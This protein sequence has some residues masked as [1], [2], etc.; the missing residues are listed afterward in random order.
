MSDDS[1]QKRPSPDALLEQAKKEGC[2][3]LKIFL[4]A[5]PGVGKTYEM[6]VQARQRK[7]EGVDIVI[8]VAETHGRVETE[9]LTK[10]FET[11]PKKRVLY[12]GLVLAEMDIDAILQRRPTLVLVDEL[13]H[14]N[15]EGSRHPKRYMDVEELLDAGIDVYTTLNIQ[16]V[17][18][19]NDI[20]A[21]ITRIQVRETVPDSIIDR[22]DDIEVVDLTPDDLIRR[23]KDGKVYLPETAERAIRNYFT[24]GNLTALREL[25]LRLTAQRVDAQMRN[26]M[27]THAIEGPWEAG[28]RVLVCINAD[29]GCFGLVRYGRR[30][31]DRLKAPW[32][33]IHVET[34]REQLTESERDR[35]ADCLRLAQRL[36][37]E[38]V[39]IPAGDIAEGIVGY[40]QANNFTHL[41]LARTRRTRLSEII[42]GSTAQ[43]IMR[44]SGDINVHVISD[45]ESEDPKS[46]RVEKIQ[47][48][49]TGPS[50]LDPRSYAGSFVISLGAL[51]VSLVLRHFG[52]TNVALVFLA[53]VLACAVTY[54]LWP[55]LF[56]CLLSV[57][58]YNFFFLPPLYTFTIADPENVVALF[59]FLVVALIGSNLAARLRAQVVAARE[60]AKTTEDLYLFSRKLG[61]IV[62]L[63]DLLWA[64][65]YQIA[66]MLKLR[67]VVLLPE[68]GRLTVRTGYPP[69]DVLS[70]ADLAAAK[71][72][73]ENNA[74]T[75]RGADTLPGAR[76]LFLPMRTGRGV[77]GV[78]GLDRDRPG[79]MLSPDQRRLLDAL[80]DQAALAIERIKLAEDV[81]RAKIAAESERLRNA[82]L[83]SISHDLRTPLA[84]IIGAATGLKTYRE[85]LDEESQRELIRTIQEEADRLNHF[86]GNLLD[87]TRLESG[88]IEPHLD[89]VDLSD[90]VG[91]ALRR[92]AKILADHKTKLAL[93]PDLPML[94]LDP[95]L[96][97]QV[98]FNLL[99]NAAKY[100]PPQ[101]TIEI[102]AR[103]DGDVV[104]LEILDEGDGIP[105]ADLERIFDKFYRVHVGDRRRVG[106]GLGLAICRGFVEAMGGTI[107]AG[108]R[109][110]RKG[111]MFTI[112][113]PVPAEQ[114]SLEEKAA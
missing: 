41:V 27:Q 24:H 83:T 86:I 68:N 66:S 97:E 67:V 105:Q 109:P 63:D 88:A 46:R 26:Y 104:R 37:G 17:E 4:G 94:K 92:T 22:A 96:F 33:V 8:G 103:R 110:D 65:A 39:T 111:A 18:S 81:D 62:L 107:R 42:R 79:P 106:T 114:K 5:A 60:R 50:W 82:L 87:M 77:I 36:G 12:K 19:L 78:V 56:A 112:T 93:A 2:G 59:F 20:V 101:T 69:E 64:T 40:A 48:I 15:V 89:P 71:W 10:G 73:F 74:P 54:G 98:L 99:D 61:G 38:A 14:T 85:S 70:D 113:L 11:I 29:P 90:I 1:A 31:A 30:I 49:D 9:L 80:A 51:L 34:A 28:D 95:V 84:S 102:R 100:A 108:N 53:G 6:L 35:V 76:R 16:H 13:A 72:C 47:T 44:R 21:R 91:S 52:I 3:R 57:L 75:G 32:T 45:R 43:R 25:A 58:A 23:L 7:L 55:A